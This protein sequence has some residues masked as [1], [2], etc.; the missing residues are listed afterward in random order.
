MNVRIPSPASSAATADFAAAVRPQI[1]AAI[2]RA[3]A[4]TGV[5]AA[6]LMRQAELE[7]G[8]NASA[9]AAT[10]SATGLYQFIEQT[11]LETVKKH[12]A[13][14]GLAAEAASIKRLP[15]GRLTAGAAEAEIL[16]RRKDPVAA[17]EMAAALAS[18]NQRYL[19]AKTGRSPNDTDLY[20]AHFLGAAGAAKFLNAREQAPDQSAAQ[21]LPAAA[22]VNRSVFFDGNSRPRSVD[23]IYERFARKFQAEGQRPAL[24]E[25]AER[26]L[27]RSQPERRFAATSR[28]DALAATRRWVAALPAG[29]GNAGAPPSITA[30]SARL[31]YLSLTDTRI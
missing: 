29:P 10:S 19:E 18:D 20:L 16:A 22:N 1:A 2:E 24:E 23:E 5:D 30:T 25:R 4:G 17:A 11:W 7:S 6:F 31:L 12:G 27:T 28:N 21:L 15:G 9:E 3:G 8:L 26:G 14:H 13:S